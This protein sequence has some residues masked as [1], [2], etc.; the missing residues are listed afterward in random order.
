MIPTLTGLVK[1]HKNDTPIRPVIN[2]K[3]APGYKLA[4]M[5]ARKLTSYIPLPFTYNVT[6]MVQSMNDLT[7]FPHDHNIKFAALDISSMYSNIP[8]Q[9]VITTIKKL[10]TVN[11]IDGRTTRDII[12]ITKTL[13]EQNY[14]HLQDTI[15][16]QNK[17]L[18]MGAPTSSIL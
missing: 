2:W 4:K 15:Y 9:D 12:R 18:A 11:N 1:L 7:D 13:T 6:N 5:L 3:N 16:I 8:T 17:G 14:F 10:R